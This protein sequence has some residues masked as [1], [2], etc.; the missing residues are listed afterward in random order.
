MCNAEG[1]AVVAVLFA[2]IAGGTPTRDA[3]ADVYIV[4]RSKKLR[5]PSRTY[6]CASHDRCGLPVACPDRRVLTKLLRN[7]RNADK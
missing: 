1:P 5:H 2:V 6:R 4:A 7:F 3:L